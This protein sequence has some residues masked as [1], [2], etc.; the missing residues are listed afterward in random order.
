MA[1]KAGRRCATRCAEENVRK[2]E[3]KKEELSCNDRL[4]S[5]SVS[6]L[7]GAYPGSDVS[8]RRSYELICGNQASHLPLSPGLAHRS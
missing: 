1:E 8:R 4:A 6:R 5:T 3:N 2:T 7:A